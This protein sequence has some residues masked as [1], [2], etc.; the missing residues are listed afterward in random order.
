M[1]TSDFLYDLPEQLIAQTPAEPRDSSRLMVI[2][3]GGDVVGHK[4]FCDLPACLR[5]GDVLVV[6][7]TRVLPARL[8]GERLPGGGA[9]EVLLLRQI[10]PVTWETLVRPGRRLKTG[11]TVALAEA[12]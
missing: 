1:K 9:C 6:N 5:A 8:I 4:R 2:G 7:D 3:R 11:A 10:S 12:G